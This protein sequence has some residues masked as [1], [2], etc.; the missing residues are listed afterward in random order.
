MMRWLGQHVQAFAAAMSKLIRS[1]IASVLN[2]LVLGIALALPLALYLALRNIESLGARFDTTPSLSVFMERGATEAEIAG[3]RQVLEPHPAIKRVQ[4]IPKDR[5][6]REL[7]DKIGLESAAIGYNPLPD[8]FIVQAKSAETTTLGNL[9]QQIGELP[10]VAHVELDH[11]WVERLQAILTLGKT[12]VLALGVMLSLA[13][14]LVSFNTIRL[15]IL[16][17][18]E[19]IEVANLIG[20]TRAFVR[21]PFLYSGAV[22]GLTGGLAALG[23]VA[24]IG[25][26]IG[27]RFSEL[28]ATYS[29]AFRG[30]GLH[31]RDAASFLLF[32]AALGWLGA[33]L[34]AYRHLWRD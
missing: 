22:Q 21:R 32:A 15:Q 10:G 8:A 33:W 9:Q 18:R 31:L 23:I 20:A 12:S 16:T 5:A 28:L 6:Y 14:T 26:Y 29:T 30:T 7:Q 34:A 2:I 1:P 13:L 25:S 17:Q 3:V 24:L 27:P 19:E 11:A 4:W